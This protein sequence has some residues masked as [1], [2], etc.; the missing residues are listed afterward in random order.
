[1]FRGTTPRLER[2][3]SVKSPEVLQTAGD[4]FFC[5]VLIKTTDRQTGSP[6]AVTESQRLGFRTQKL[7]ALSP[8]NQELP[9][10][11]SS[12]LCKAHCIGFKALTVA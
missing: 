5:S 1:M 10:E 6:L 7:M 2:N 3:F 4:G 8:E 11:E 12:P 9:K